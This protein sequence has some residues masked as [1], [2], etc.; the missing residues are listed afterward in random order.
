MHVSGYGTGVDDG[1]ETFADDAVGAIHGEEGVS[2]R[3]EG[4]EG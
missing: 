1:V 3:G 4:E 2:G